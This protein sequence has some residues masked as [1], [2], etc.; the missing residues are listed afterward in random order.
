MSSFKDKVR[1]NFDRSAD[2]YDSAAII[3]KQIASDLVELLLQRYPNFKPLKALDIGS[4]TGFIP[5]LLKDI[6]PAC[7]WTLN[8]VSAAMLTK[9]KSKLGEHRY[10]YWQAD[11]ENADITFHDLII[12]NLTFQW[13]DNLPAVLSKLAKNCQVLAFT[14]L[15]NGTFQSWSDLFTKNKVISP[16]AEYPDLAKIEVICKDLNPDSMLSL[17]SDYLI[18]FDSALEFSRYLKNLGVNS[19]KNSFDSARLK[20]IILSSDSEIEAEYKTALIIMKFSP[21]INS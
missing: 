9:A 20:K 15:T 8:D 3:Q 13:F 6:Y 7:H 19:S 1:E 17:S 11:P 4:G 2:T 10:N 16:V 18:S 12:S 14:T 5:L 21:A